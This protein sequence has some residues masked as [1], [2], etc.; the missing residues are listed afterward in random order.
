MLILKIN[1]DVDKQNVVCV[2]GDG[3]KELTLMTVI[4]N[5][6]RSYVFFLHPGPHS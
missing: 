4:Y 1:V 5:K 2:I 6:A 3:E